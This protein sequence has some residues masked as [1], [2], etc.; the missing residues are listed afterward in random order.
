MTLERWIKEQDKKGN[1][2]AVG[3]GNA[4][5]QEF[6]DISLEDKTDFTATLKKETKEYKRNPFSPERA[7][8]FWQAFWNRNGSKTDF[9][10][11]VV[12]CVI[13]ADQI[14][15]ANKSGIGLIY[16]PENASTQLERSLL[17]EMFPKM[18]SHSVRLGDNE[19]RN[20]ESH[21]GWRF[22]DIQVRPLVPGTTE[23]QV[24]IFMQGR[25]AEAPTLN[26]YIIA[27]QSAKVLTGKYLDEAHY[28]SRLVGSVFSGDTIVARFASNGELDVV[29]W[30]ADRYASR[31]GARFSFPAS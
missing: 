18:H 29:P 22:F 13:T 1:I 6:G 23:P 20:I 27:S 24:K 17:G 30:K 5:L 14:R 4:L 9:A 8:A 26:E 10:V 12:P 2:R 15:I 19:V 21:Y 3:L 31:V 7:T 25:H 28:Y 11:D 16:V